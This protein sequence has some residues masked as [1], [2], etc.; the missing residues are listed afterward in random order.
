MEKPGPRYQALG[1]YVRIKKQLRELSHTATQDTQRVAELRM[2]F[3]F[4]LD[5]RELFADVQQG[6]TRISE[7]LSLE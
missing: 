4:H 6:E 1:L 7:R 5:H 2:S 3:Q